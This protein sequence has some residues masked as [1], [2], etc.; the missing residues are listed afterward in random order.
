MFRKLDKQH[1]ARMLPVMK[2]SDAIVILGE[3]KPTSSTV[4]TSGGK[5]KIKKTKINN[6]FAASGPCFLSYLLTLLA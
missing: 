2:L 1:E 6:S 3:A 4:T 5:L